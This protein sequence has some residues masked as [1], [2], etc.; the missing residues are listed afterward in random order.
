VFYNAPSENLSFPV[1]GVITASEI[2][3]FFPKW[4]LARNVIFRFASNRLTNQIPAEM[5][6]YLRHLNPSK[7]KI[8]R[9]TFCH[10]TQKTMRDL[11]HE[12]PIMNTTN[13]KW[14]PE[15]KLWTMGRHIKNRMKDWFRPWDEENLLPDTLG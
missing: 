6:N 5:H 11:R 15:L 3:A 8:D 12:I 7:R 13:R 4:L 2:F 9:V 10:I 14:E 1:W